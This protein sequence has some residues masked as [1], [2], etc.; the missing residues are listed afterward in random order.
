MYV[1]FSIQYVHLELLC[2][3]GNELCAYNVCTIQ[4]TICTPRTVMCTRFQEFPYIKTLVLTSWS[5]SYFS[6]DIV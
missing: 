2:A 4:Y 6:S 5:R 1:Q 3:P